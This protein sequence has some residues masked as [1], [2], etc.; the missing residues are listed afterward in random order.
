MALT[1]LMHMK[2]CGKGNPARHLKNGIV[3]IMQEKKTD[4]GR[5][6]GGTLGA[7]GRRSIIPCWR[8]SRNL[9]SR[10]DGRDTIS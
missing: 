1:K 5:W 10:T 8:P 2:Q 9:E 6:I 7:P 3:Y 4:H